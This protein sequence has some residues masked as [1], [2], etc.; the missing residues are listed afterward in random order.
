M[1]TKG[2]R[3]RSFLGLKLDWY[4]ALGINEW[5]CWQ[6]LGRCG[7]QFKRLTTEP[8]WFDLQGL[9]A[10]ICPEHMERNENVCGRGKK[11]LVDIDGGICHDIGILSRFSSG[12]TSG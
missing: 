11:T 4:K 9:G 2:E 12:F 8:N 10:K 6:G 3:G 7:F 1:V 5:S